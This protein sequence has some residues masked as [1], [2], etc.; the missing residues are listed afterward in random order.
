MRELLKSVASRMKGEKAQSIHN[1]QV[2]MGGGKS[3]TLLLLYYLSKHPEKVLPF[4]KK[5]KIADK[6]PQFR[7]VV[8]DGSRIDMFGKRYP[9]GTHIKTLWGLLFKALG[10]YQKYKDIDT[11]GQAP[12]V[13]TLKEALSAEPTLILI[14]EPT[15]YIQ[16]IM[17]DNRHIGVFQA[18]L[19][20]LTT[21]VSETPGCALVVTAPTGIYEEAR[22]LI[23]EVLSRFCA[24]T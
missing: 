8:I 1:L 4:L 23:S 5:E 17:G 16:N 20:N 7:I 15:I 18:F 9:D 12:S 24:P 10:V 14:D 22:R 3:H 13:T 2:G 21:A 11:L 6:V 19:Q